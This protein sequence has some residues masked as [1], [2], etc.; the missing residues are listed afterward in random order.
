MATLGISARDNAL[1]SSAML[2]ITHTQPKDDAKP[3]VPAATSEFND[4]EYIREVLQLEEGK[5]EAILD[6]DLTALAEE[7]GITV[8][9]PVNMKGA[10]NPAH[11]S[12]CD[13]STTFTTNHARTAST[14]SR[15]STSTGI[16]S[17]SSNEGLNGHAHMRRSLS[18][19]DYDK[20]IEGIE[21]QA[22]LSGAMVPPPIPTESAAPSMFSVSTRKSYQ[23]IKSTLKQRFRLKRNKLPMEDSK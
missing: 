23:S 22:L 15:A 8:A 18:F 21:A 10:A 6:N 1:P 19:T 13:S 9:Q 4:V 7:L 17:R 12:V 3:L 16:T 20:F 14:G 5:T 2:P 11:S